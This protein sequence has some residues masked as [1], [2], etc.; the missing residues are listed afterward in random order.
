MPLIILFAVLAFLA[1]LGYAALRPDEFSLS[2]SVT[3]MAPPER[4][5]PLIND[6]KLMN[7]WNPFVL[8]DPNIKLDYSGPA[9]GVGARCDWD[10][11]A[12]AGAGNLAISASRP[13]SSI[14]MQL[15]MLRPF[16]GQNLVTFRLAPSGAATTVTWGMTGASSD[17]SKLMGLVMS[18][19]KMVG[20]AMEKGLADLKATAERSKRD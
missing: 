6:M 20:G 14:D 16:P 12:R 10:S 1:A 19:D 7:S 15:T 5:F 8:A 9:A 2:R 11:K 3:I 18:M 13:S 17:L 4:I